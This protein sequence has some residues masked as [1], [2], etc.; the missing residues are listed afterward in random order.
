MFRYIRYADHTLVV[1]NTLLL[2]CVAVQPFTTA[3]LAEYFRAAP[4]DRQLAVALYGVPMIVGGVFFNAIWWHAVR[5]RLVESEADRARL[6]SLGRHWRLGPILY[7]AAFLLTFL[8]AALAILLY[9]VLLVHFG[10]S[11]TWLVGGRRG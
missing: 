3:L 7:L 8:N 11:G 1:L 5:A 9:A 2:L 4:A 10:R 6:V